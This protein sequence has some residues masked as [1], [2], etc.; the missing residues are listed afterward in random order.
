ML[1]L[2]I[3]Q[4]TNSQYTSVSSLHFKVSFYANLYTEHAVPGMVRR[5]ADSYIGSEQEL[6][7]LR[8]WNRFT[9]DSAF[10][11]GFKKE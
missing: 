11:T 10:G 8:D 9:F 2:F 1:S 4:Y 7:L 6:Y 3:H 5:P